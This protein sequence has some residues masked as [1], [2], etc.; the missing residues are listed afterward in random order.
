MF[1]KD[2]D[3]YDFVLRPNYG[4]RKITLVSRQHQD[5]IAYMNFIS[6]DKILVV[7]RFGKVVVF[8]SQGKIVNLTNHSKLEEMEGLVDMSIETESL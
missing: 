7:F 6:N 4:Q 3:K 1:K 5:E 2:K 8:N